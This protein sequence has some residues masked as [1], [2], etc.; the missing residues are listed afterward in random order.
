VAGWRRRWRTSTWASSRRRETTSPTSSPDLRLSDFDY[1][2]P[3]ELIAQHPPETRGESRLMVVPAQG[4]IGHEDF[5]ILP[6]LL[7]PGDLLVVNDSRVLPARLRFT[8]G[9]KAAEVLLLREERAD[10]WEALMRPGKR[11]RPGT[12][13][14]LRPGLWADVVSR[15]PG[16]LFS[17]RFSPAGRLFALLPE[18]G[19]TPLPPY[20]KERLEDAERYQTVYAREPGSAAAPTAGLHFTDD[21][22]ARLAA[23]HVEVAFL[24]LHI[25]LDTF[26]P[27]RVADLEDHRMHSEFYAIPAATRAAIDAAREREGRVV[28]VGTTVARALEAA[29]MRR[30]PGQG[31]GEAA[32]SGATDIFIRPGHTWREVDMLLTNF[33]LPR[34]TLL[35]MVSAFAGRE[36][37]L[38]AYAEAI[39]RRYRFYSFGDAMLLEPALGVRASGGPH[40]SR[41]P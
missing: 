41:S 3:Q 27:L 16:G 25:G 14:Q 8:W 21:M 18:I 10:V 40:A 26:Q 39:E 2:L 31:E 34:S 6:R 7:R 11:V 32:D 29:A 1:A 4:A 15:Q 20:I 17:L 5:D 33:H 9:E 24:T 36:R 22:L 37:V 19:E 12:R 35:V 28:A 30:A 23:A 38:E 13:L